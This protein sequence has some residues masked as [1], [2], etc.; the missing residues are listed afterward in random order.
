MLDKVK[1]ESRAE[2][3]IKHFNSVRELTE[4]LCQGLEIED[5]NL[6]AIAE[7][8][9]AKWH[10]AHTSWF[11]ET[12]ILKDFE[13][14]F[15]P[16]HPEFEYLFNSY[17]NSVGEQFLRPNRH[18]LSRPTVD[19]VLQY[20]HEV[21]R[22]ITALLEAITQKQIKEV[23][24]LV[25]LGINHEQQHQELLLTDLKYNLYQNPLLPRYSHKHDPD[26]NNLSKP[27]S[28]IWVEYQPELCTV[29]TK[30]GNG[31]TGDF[32]FDNESPE[33]Q[34]Y[35][36]GFKVSNRLVTNAEYLEFIEQGGYERAE[37]WLSDGWSVKNQ[38]QWS[39][40][41]YWFK[42][43]GAWHYYTL[44]GAQPLALNEPVSHVSYYEADAFAAWKGARLPT[45]QEWERVASLQAVNGPFLDSDNL[46]PSPETK[47]SKQVM[48]LFGQLWQWTSSHYSSYPGYQPLAGGVGEYNGK[49]MA[50]QYVLRGGSCV[51]SRD[52]LR[53]TYRNFFY[54]ESRWQF[55]G[56][57][58][59]KDL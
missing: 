14:D 43:G 52:H 19:E 59:A 34:H 53:A 18:L 44:H 51:S 28:Q 36:Q 29:G 2:D 38:E 12:F 3:I 37:L 42:K 49:F 55:S 33:H 21:T 32:C 40:P 23:L 16:Y 54:P 22:R 47:E 35:L 20:R 9:P 45:E 30:L 17:Y 6:Q 48:Q 41:L 1:T 25:V 56:I 27:V 5:Y 31:V 58:L 4:S 26:K 57:R 7:T 50:N 11:F 24:P 46:S 39:A 10:L 8:S 13:S 15:V